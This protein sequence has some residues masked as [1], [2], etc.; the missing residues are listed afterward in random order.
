M[1]IT[2]ELK[3]VLSRVRPVAWI[4][5]ICGLFLIIALNETLTTLYKNLD[6]LW[7]VS[8]IIGLVAILS[9]T[10]FSAISVQGIL[11]PKRRK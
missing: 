7:Q 11:K 4:A 5:M 3:E 6:L 8:V 1:R 9:I 10:G 2:T